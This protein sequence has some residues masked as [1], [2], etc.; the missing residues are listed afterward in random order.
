MNAVIWRRSTSP[1]DIAVPDV[2]DWLL[3]LEY[4]GAPLRSEDAP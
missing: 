3:A 2:D 4:G 1:A